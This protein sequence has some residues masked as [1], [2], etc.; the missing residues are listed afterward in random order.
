MCIAPGGKRH[1]HQWRI[2]GAS[3]RKATAVLIREDFSGIGDFEQLLQFIDAQIRPIHMI[4][5]LAIYDIAQRIGAYLGIEP[6]DVYLHAGTKQG[7]TAIGLGRGRNKLGINEFPEE[8]R[9]LS[10]SEIEDC[11]CIYKDSLKRLN[12]SE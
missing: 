12:A 3:L 1:P 4:G 8:F 9:R 6:D 5:D 11:L 7:A 2:P 10:A